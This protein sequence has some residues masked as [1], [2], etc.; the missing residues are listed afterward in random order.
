MSVNRFARRRIFLM[1]LM[2]PI[3]FYAFHGMGYTK[4]DVKQYFPVTSQ[5]RKLMSVS[6]AQKPQKIVILYGNQRSGSTFMGEM[7][8][9]NTNAF[10]L[11]EP[12]FP[13]TPHCHFFNEERLETLKKMM[14]CQF[15]DSASAFKLARNFTKASDTV[16][17]CVINNACF[18]SRSDALS[19][20]YKQFCKSS[21]FLSIAQKCEFPLRADVIS[22]ICSQT[23]V[24]A[25]KVLRICSLKDIEEIYKD[26]KKRGKDVYV[27]H[28]LRDPRAIISSKLKLEL[29]ESNALQ[30][31]GE[32]CSRIHRNLEYINGTTDPPLLIRDEK[33]LRIRYEDASMEPISTASKIYGFLGLELPAEVEGWLKM[34][35]IQPHKKLVEIE[36]KLKEGESNRNAVLKSFITLEKQLRNP[37][38]T[39]RDPSTTVQKWRNSMS[40]STV[41]GIQKIC[42]KVLEK[43]NYTTVNTVAELADTTKILW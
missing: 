8:N 37:Y 17:G 15:S 2:T 23:E 14:N 26:F 25:F 38:G 34:S 31:A 18:A 27:I 36:K 24:V 11:Y 33:Y 22:T 35:T 6:N 40:F 39:I 21:T 12:L 9:K 7:F 30:K 5:I 42:E 3:V 10:Y 20:R 4:I 1:G 29:K 43:L 28:L 13:Y 16:S 41:S 32:L 19:I